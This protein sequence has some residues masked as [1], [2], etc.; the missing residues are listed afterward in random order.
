MDE[1]D[2]LNKSIQFYRLPF[3]Y[4]YGKNTLF[5]LYNRPCLKLHQIMKLHDCNIDTYGNN[6][7]KIDNTPKII[8]KNNGNLNIYFNRN[9]NTNI[10]NFTLIKK[11]AKIE[12]WGCYMKLNNCPFGM[13]HDTNR[14]L[15]K[16]IVNIYN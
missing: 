5:T 14:F 6:K 9:I 1:I 10:L 15:Y 13:Y 2:I 8:K 7:H 4:K 12:I 16:K 3:C 11:T